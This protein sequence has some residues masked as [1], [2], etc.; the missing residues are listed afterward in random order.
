[1]DIHCAKCGEPW[2][3]TGGL[4]HSHSDMT[5]WE[6]EQLVQGLGC[7]CCGGT[8]RGITGFQ[9]EWLDSLRALSEGT[10]VTEEDVKER[11]RS[12][13]ADYWQL[14]PPGWWHSLSES[15]S[16]VGLYGDELWYCFE[17][18]IPMRSGASDTVLQAN[19]DSAYEIFG[20]A[21]SHR[22]R[23]LIGTYDEDTDAL[24]FDEVL[25]KRAVEFEAA[26]E[27]YPVYDEERLSA[28]EHER[29]EEDRDL[30]VA[31]WQDE[32]EQLFRVQGSG[33]LAAEEAIKREL[34]RGY[35]KEE[36]PTFEAFLAE[37]DGAIR[38]HIPSPAGW[39]TIPTVEEGCYL[40][41]LEDDTAPWRGG[42]LVRNEGNDREW[43]EEFPDHHLKRNTWG[44][45]DNCWSEISAVEQFRILQ[46]LDGV[47]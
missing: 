6:Y 30:M 42:L 26:L 3:S 21:L 24:E 5:W 41:R 47:G 11:R 9:D 17:D 23:V 29:R 7:P 12:W 2:D 33:L 31:R 19:W 32:I 46:A 16:G 4:H 36:Y 44:C 25:Y 38:S 43:V 20:T 35:Y 8:Q 40:L 34:F 15:P 13:V 28:L 22:N 45:Y 18:H 37:H 14:T 1:M 10:I 39:R 27:D